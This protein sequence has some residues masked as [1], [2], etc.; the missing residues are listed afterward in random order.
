[1]AQKF[2]SVVS[3]IKQLIE[4]IVTSAGEV[5]AGKIPA[6]DASG[7]IS[8]TMMPVGIGPDT[9]N[10]VASEALAAGDLVNIWDNAGTPNVRKADASTSGKEAVGFVLAGVTSGAIATVYF[11][12]TIT[13]L[14]GLTAG[15]RYYLSAT[16]PG[17]TTTTAPA[18][19]GQ[20]VQY[21][22]RAV[23]STELSFEPD[24]SVVL[25]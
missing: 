19:T 15:T 10:I 23:S 6:L 5:D 16:T 7:R 21:V 18:T 17:Q 11:E 25:G 14:T 4:A 13:G 12:G 24:D 8:Q 22:G 20:V 1:M 9:K 2:L 3:G